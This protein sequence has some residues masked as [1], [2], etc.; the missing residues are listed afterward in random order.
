MIIEQDYATLLDMFWGYS[1]ISADLTA[2]A[3]VICWPRIFFE[4]LDLI[5]VRDLNDQGLL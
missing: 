1:L 3:A 2:R 4:G 5:A